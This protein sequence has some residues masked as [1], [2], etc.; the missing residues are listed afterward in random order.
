[1]VQVAMRPNVRVDAARRQLRYGNVVDYKSPDSARVQRVVGVRCKW[2]RAT[3]TIRRANVAQR[4]ATS[5]SHS[6]PPVTVSNTQRPN[7]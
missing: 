4:G 5:Q 6:T 1:M 7:G 2:D 3:H